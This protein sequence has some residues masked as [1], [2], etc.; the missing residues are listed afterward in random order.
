MPPKKEGIYLADYS[1]CEAYFQTYLKYLSNYQD[2]SESFSHYNPF[3]SVVTSPVDFTTAELQVIKLLLFKLDTCEAN[4]NPSYR[5]CR[6]GL[7]SA[8]LSL[9]G[10]YSN[11]P[12]YRVLD[13]PYTPKKCF[14]TVSLD[15][16]IDT[17]LQDAKFGMQHTPHLKIKLNKNIELCIPIMH[18]IKEY[19]DS[20]ERKYQL[21]VDANSDWTP[22]IALA[23]LP[24]F[25]KMKDVLTIVEQPFPWNIATLATEEIN[26][27]VDV[28]EKYMAEGLK[29]YADE[30]V[31]TSKDVEFLQKICNGVNIKL[32]KTGGIREAL[33]TIQMARSYN[34]DV[35]MGIMVSS[36]LTN[37]ATSTLLPL[38]DIG[39]DLDGQLLIEESS[40]LFLGGMNWDFKTGLV[41]PPKGNGLGVIV[42][43]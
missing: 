28:K 23:Y 7:E 10:D 31:S 30:S 2:V 13:I 39:G 1:D 8:L 18:Q 14:Y 35:W 22:E 16:S 11:L 4:V 36:S 9:V 34:L 19:M 42:K 27:W 24:T 3:E 38:T 29:I 43:E 5:V 37:A 17:M 15:P 12:L 40:D 26:K 6:N 21:M 33:R 32:D 20:I 25:T 41:T